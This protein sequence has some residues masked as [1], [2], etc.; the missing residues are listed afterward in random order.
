MTH[1][2]FPEF[3]PHVLLRGGHRQTLAGIFLPGGRFPEQAV[4][5]Q[6][7]L[8]D[9]D[10]VIL[11]DDCPDDWQ[12]TN[13]TALLVHGM[14]GC[15]QSPYM[16]RVAA[17]LKARGV[18]AFRMDL[19]GSGAG[20]GLARRPYH[21]GRSDDVRATVEFIETITAAAPLTLVGFSLGGA[22]VLKC[23]GEG[24]DSLPANIN[25]AA[26]VC[27]PLD[28][29]ECVA[30]LRRRATRIY[31]RYFVRLLH[32]QI[33][34]MKPLRPDGTNF[35]IGP[36]PT[37]LWDFDDTVTA[38]LGGFQSA[39]D[40]Y[41]RC[42]PEQFL[43]GIRTPTLFLA[44]H[45]D[46]LVPTSDDAKAALAANPHVHPQFVQTGGHLGFIARNGNDP[47]RRWMDWRIV[48]WIVNQPGS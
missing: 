5:H 31:E 14:A 44:A 20:A 32:Q 18:R 3:R 33:V 13:A 25:R 8:P 11:H 15:H 1:N 29:A 48:D 45:D 28:L 2:T 46:P 27:P 40:Y 36:R 10:V 38:P 47:N 22:M 6:V 41:E 4:L 23:L 17:K 26:V 39:K 19:R 43:A 42:H 12:P 37:S 21:A 7:T 34:E 35:S 9:G 30:R 24:S 16:I